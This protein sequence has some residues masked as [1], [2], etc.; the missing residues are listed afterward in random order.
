MELVKS[1]GYEVSIGA[2]EESDLNS[3]IE[4]KF[5][6][7]K[8]IVLLDE[9]GLKHCWSYLHSQVPALNDAEII[10]VESGE[11][12]KNIETCTGIWSALADMNVSRHDLII[13]L[14]G[15]VIGD[16]GGFIASTFKR[17]MH[18]VQVPTTLL[19]QV[20]ASI[21]GKVGV[22]LNHM[23]NMIGVINQPNGVYVDTNFLKTLPS[24]HLKSGLAEI[25]KHGL[26]S[27][28]K[29][30]NKICDKKYQSVKDF[31]DLVN[32]S[33]HIK[34]GIVNQ[35]PYEQNV[36]KK[37]NFGHTIGHA[38]EAYS[39]ESAMKSLLHGEAIAIGMICESFLSYKKDLLSEEELASITTFINELYPAFIMNEVI[40]HRLI[41]F[42][43]NDKKNRAGEIN[44]TLLNG[45]GDSSINHSFDIPD[46]FESLEYYQKSIGI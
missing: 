7:S 30:W 20:D 2:I 26:V 13:N 21:G 1:Q 27:D 6:N 8:K 22:D 44:F 5:S 43:K 10:E 19:A 14:G 11:K 15:G 35:D 25:I 16:M 29:Y 37:L 33:V 46:I 31:G 3:W 4:E 12:N 23:K 39:L 17:G 9:N 32:Q 36:R 41:E 18:F 24:N 34:N 42:M 45:I 28:Q 40:Y 38:I